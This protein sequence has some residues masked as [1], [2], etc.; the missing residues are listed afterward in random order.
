MLLQLQWNNSSGYLGLLQS[1]D[2]VSKD[3]RAER[4]GNFCGSWKNTE[5][6]QRNWGADAKRKGISKKGKTDTRETR[7]EQTSSLWANGRREEA[8]VRLACTQTPLHSHLDS[9]QRE[10]RRRRQGTTRLCHYS[11]VSKR[12]R[13]LLQCWKRSAASSS[14]VPCCF[15]CNSNTTGGGR[16]RSC[17]SPSRH[18]CRRRTRHH[19]YQHCCASASSWSPPPPSTGKELLRKETHPGYQT[20]QISPRTRATPK[21]DPGC[22]P[23]NSSGKTI[24]VS[25]KREK[26]FDFRS[27]SE[28][29]GFKIS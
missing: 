1:K 5:P 21:T 3:T 13:R 9:P 8:L 25:E 29:N 4:Y 14:D 16:A 19:G 20:V 17:S 6:K 22:A 10:R 28:R 15:C 11:P 24:A 2:P 7:G 18:H 12:L 26:Q 23:R 27:I